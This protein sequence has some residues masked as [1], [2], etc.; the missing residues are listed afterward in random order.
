M[1]G[2]IRGAVGNEDASA[3]REGNVFGK[4]VDLRFERESVFGVGAG[5]A[6][7]DIDAVAGFYFCDAW[8]DRVDYAGAVGAGSVGKLWKHGVIAGAGIGVGG[9]DACG[10]D[11]D[12]DLSGG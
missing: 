10:V 3:L 6:F 12:E 7:G 4:A 11:F 2:V 8:A 1:Q 9:I 5:K